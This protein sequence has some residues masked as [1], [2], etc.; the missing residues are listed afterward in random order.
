VLTFGG[1]PRRCETNVKGKK[2]TGNKKN[3]K[4]KKKVPKVP[5]KQLQLTGFSTT[6]Y[7][8]TKKSQSNTIKSWPVV[9]QEETKKKKRKT[10]GSL[11]QVTNPDYAFASFFSDPPL[12]IENVPFFFIILL[13]SESVFSCRFES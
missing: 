4:K 10:K 12:P 9:D 6:G 13:Q 2:K 1:R 11:H 8:K 5:N 7:K 3:K